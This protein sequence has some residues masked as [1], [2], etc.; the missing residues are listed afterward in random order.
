KKNGLRTPRTGIPIISEEEARRINPRSFFV[1]PWHFRDESIPRE[2]P[3]LEAGGRLVFPLPRFEIVGKNA[4]RER[5][6]VSPPMPSANTGHNAW[7]QP[8]LFGDER[9]FI[10]EALDS[11][12]ISGG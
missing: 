11:T 9:S 7:A 4:V 6:H 8:M 3:F 1:F 10:A 5:T 2:K 12:M